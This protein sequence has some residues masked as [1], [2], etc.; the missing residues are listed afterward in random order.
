[1][2][3]F[4]I[5]RKTRISYDLEKDLGLPLNAREKKAYSN[6]TEKDSNYFGSL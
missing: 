4:Y 1:M 5:N 6:T 2:I 3:K